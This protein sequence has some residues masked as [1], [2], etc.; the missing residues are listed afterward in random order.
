[1]L[2]DH[3][4]NLCTDQCN[5]DSNTFLSFNIFLYFY[6]LIRQWVTYKLQHGYYPTLRQVG[7]L[8]LHGYYP[9]LHLFHKRNNSNNKSSRPPIKLPPKQI[10]QGYPWKLVAL[11]HNQPIELLQLTNPE[12]GNKPRLKPVLITTSEHINITVITGYKAITK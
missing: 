6:I 3:Y 8:L 9:H 4:T 11:V 10:W 2:E 5:N 1:M 7:N 12:K